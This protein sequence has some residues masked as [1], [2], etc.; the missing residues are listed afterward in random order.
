MPRQVAQPLSTLLQRP[1]LRRPEKRAPPATPPQQ[2]ALLPLQKKLRT[3]PHRPLC[4]GSLN[5]NFHTPA[6]QT[7]R[8][9]K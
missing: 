7:Q 9:R 3:Q 8:R 1:Q 5:W 2:D 4:R 6:K